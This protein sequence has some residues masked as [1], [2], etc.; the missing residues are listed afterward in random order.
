[1]D[2]YLGSYC[3]I[4]LGVEIKADRNFFMK[5]RTGRSYR[6]AQDNRAMPPGT[7]QESAALIRM[8]PVGAWGWMPDTQPL[9]AQKALA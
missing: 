6:P 9:E 7:G 3:T 8:L 4:F 1:M 2:F 5:R